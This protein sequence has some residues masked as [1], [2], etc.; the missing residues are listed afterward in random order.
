MG[1]GRSIRWR[2]RLSSRLGVAFMAT[3][4]AAVAI[5]TAVALSASSRGITEL[6]AEQRA[7]VAR[8]VVAALE[9]AH[10][11]AGGWADADLLPAHTVAAAAGAVLIVTTPDLGEL[12]T[13]P[14][15][16]PTRR[17]LQAPADAEPSNDGVVPPSRD[18]QHPP[19]RRRGDGGSE[20]VPDG[21]DGQT[22]TAPAPGGA[23]TDA[24]GPGGTGS[25][26]ADGEGGAAGGGGSSPTGD[27]EDGRVRGG[28]PT[29][30]GAA[31]G[32][33]TGTAPSRPSQNSQPVGL[34]D[35]SDGSAG[36]VTIV[37]ASW[38]AR[39][40]ALDVAA[41][42]WRTTH[43]TVTS[44][45][46]VAEAPIPG[47]AEVIE[48][49]DLP[50]VI[51]GAELGTATLLFV[52][53]VQPDPVEAFRTS[54]LPRLLL[55][56]ATAALLAL[57]ITGFVTLR[58]TR[59]LRQLT[60]DV[61]HLRDDPRRPSVGPLPAAPGELGLLR[62]AIDQMADDLRRQQHLRRALIADVGHELRTPVT[63]LLAELE[64]IRDGVL[65][66][67]EDQLGSLHEEVQRIAR[68]VE[69][70]SSLADAE[71]SGFALE[72]EPLDLA[73]VTEAAACAFQ[74]PL[75]AGG[76]TLTTALEPVAV[77]G[78]RR[79]LEQVVRNLVSNATRFAPPDSA[80][81]VVVATDGDDAVLEVRDRGPGFLPEEL[82]HV[83][84]RFWRGRETV[85]TGGSGIGLAVVAE[86][87][88]AHGGSAA[89]TNRPEGGAC[90]TVRL[91]RA[92]TAVL[93]AR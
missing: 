53:R 76:V 27:I 14:E 7:A 2:D 18:Q 19:D 35:D 75:R 49:I 89:A 11:E 60:D 61:D 65:P 32:P 66:A 69:D 33:A 46:V 17:R 88:A 72:P 90:L 52:A 71:A 70:V 77:E 73:A 23:G 25:P 82:P 15:L 68:L 37:S 22:P 59:P 74:A 83:F 1:E 56:A 30:G 13:P 42:D 9:V 26:G 31:Q 67:D 87:A 36:S 6:A 28:T 8:D 58:L 81:E 50:I 10:V 41:T 51:D 62:S 47:D 40:S 44:D 12:P 78:D 57:G 34:G 16:G 55:G 38:T 84:E 5:V 24:G 45:G 4:L 92:S 79:R 43:E 29:T 21:D 86:V 39:G 48:H 3:A 64:A 63:I 54:L 80:I 91:P 93:L 20:E 85:T